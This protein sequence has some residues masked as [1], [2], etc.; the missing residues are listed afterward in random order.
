VIPGEGTILQGHCLFSQ[1]TRLCLA[2]L[3]K[4][5]KSLICIFSLTD[6]KLLAKLVLEENLYVRSLEVLDDCAIFAGCDKAML[7]FFFDDKK[8]SL[9]KQDT[10]VFETK[11]NLC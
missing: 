6:L 7:V 11:C 8:G 3:N 2:G 1:D 10:E 9:S 5:G 4:Q